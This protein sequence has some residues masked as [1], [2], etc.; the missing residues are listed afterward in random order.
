MDVEPESA[1]FDEPDE[2][3]ESVAA[4]PPEPDESLAEPSFAAPSLDAPAPEVAESLAAP[5]PESDD[6]RRLELADDR[7]FLAQP[8]PLKWIEGAENALRTGAAPQI[9]HDSGPSAVTPWITSKRW[10]FGQR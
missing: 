7:S 3:P 2:A 8:E 4:L 6:A 10:P 1:G 9:G 5:S